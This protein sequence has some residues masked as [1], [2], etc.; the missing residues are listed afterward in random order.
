MS[1]QGSYEQNICA[2]EIPYPNTSDYET[3]YK[4]EKKPLAK[5]GSKGL[6][7]KI[8][9][10]KTKEEILKNPKYLLFQEVPF[11]FRTDKDFVLQVI[12]L[13]QTFGAF[14]FFLPQSMRE[15]EDVTIRSIQHCDI[16]SYQYDDFIN[17]IP[18]KLET[19]AKVYEELCKSKISQPMLKKIPTKFQTKENVKN[20]LMKRQDD[21]SDVPDSL[22]NDEEL[23]LLCVKCFEES[24]LLFGNEKL[25]KDQDFNYKITVMNP[26]VYKYTKDK[27]NLEYFKKVLLE[28]NFQLIE[29]EIPENL[30]LDKEFFASLVKKHPSLMS[31]MPQS[32]R[33]DPKIIKELSTSK[34]WIYL[35][36]L[37]Y[38]TLMKHEE[39]YILNLIEKEPTLFRAM[40]PL[41]ENQKLV[42]IAVKNDP[43]FM[44]N[45]STVSKE[46]LLKYLQK[47]PS[48]YKKVF[49]KFRGRFGD[50]KDFFIY[51]IAEDPSNFKSFTGYTREEL[52]VYLSISGVCIYWTSPE[53]KNDK[54][55]VLIAVGCNGEALE[56]VS[57]KFYSDRDVVLTAVSSYGRALS[58]ASEEL[59]D[60]F[61]IV[62]AAVVNNGTA[63][64]FA[65][66]RLKQNPKICLAAIEQSRTAYRDLDASMK[67]QLD[68]WLVYTKRYQKLQPNLQ[69]K[70]KDIHFNFKN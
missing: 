57:S 55:L 64:K 41:H 69:G 59:I 25:K 7:G 30:M 45:V 62:M 60:D 14:Y 23:F 49:S 10:M 4:P 42:D 43:E 47:N 46:I 1:H 68:V 26:R 53:Y 52:K 19:N 39:E 17:Y 65:S 40:H 9:S 18:K 51:K 38:K 63:V 2:F 36:K 50:D 31:K 32:F 70:L 3:S 12:N 67:T 33:V 11:E 20:H 24:Y 35:P 56:F 54:E 5:K 34:T 6:N 22:K 58:F 8:S 44:E 27:L 37:C 28:V 48:K 66:K 61:E 29:A 13:D 16:S 21:Y 15:D